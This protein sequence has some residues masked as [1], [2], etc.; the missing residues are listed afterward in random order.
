MFSLFIPKSCKGLGRR[1][2]RNHR[3]GWTPGQ[4]DKGGKDEGGKGS[5]S[6]GVS[7]QSV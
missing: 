5:E 4:S 2:E 7:D 6:R 1:E 3:G